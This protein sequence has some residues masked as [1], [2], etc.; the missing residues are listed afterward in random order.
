MRYGAKSRDELSMC[1]RG[2]DQQAYR[3]WFVVVVVVFSLHRAFVRQHFPRVDSC[4][5]FVSG[6]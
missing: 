5:A 6:G 4:S 3:E 2:Q 1:M